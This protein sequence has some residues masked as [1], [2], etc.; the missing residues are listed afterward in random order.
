MADYDIIDREVVDRWGDGEGRA[1]VQAVYEKAADLYR[2]RVCY[3][4][5]NGQFGQSAPT[6]SADPETAERV[7]EAYERMAERA[8]EAE[9]RAQL[10][11][12]SDLVDRVGYNRAKE[13]LEQEAAD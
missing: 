11:E 1:E 13:I 7:C 4:R 5:D 8:R 9:E 6:I 3:Y 12:L 10:S 2:V